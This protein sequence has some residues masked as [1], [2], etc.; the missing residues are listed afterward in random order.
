MPNHS[1]IS[2]G[3]VH[4]MR[5]VLTGSMLARGIAHSALRL[6]WSI[7]LRPYRVASLLDKAHRRP[8]P[9]DDGRLTLR[10]LF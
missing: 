4:R 2:A 6:R 5:A 9:Y 10:S 1:L 3:C 7:P 8:R